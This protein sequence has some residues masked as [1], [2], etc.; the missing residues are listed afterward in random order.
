MLQSSDDIRP[1]MRAISAWNETHLATWCKETE[2]LTID[3][4]WNLH[5]VPVIFV[6][7][8]NINTCLKRYSVIKQ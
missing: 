8:W 2:F 7:N 6:R 3:A 4:C 5:L 1:L